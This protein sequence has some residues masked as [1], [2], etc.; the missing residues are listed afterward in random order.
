MSTPQPILLILCSNSERRQFLLKEAGFRFAVVPSQFHEGGVSF[1]NPIVTGKAIARGKIETVAA[2]LPAE[3][4]ALGESVKSPVAPDVTLI[5]CDTMVELNGMI[6]GK[7]SDHGDARRILRELSGQTHRVYS[8]VAIQRLGPPPAPAAPVAGAPAA[9]PR[10]H[11][12]IH[13]FTVM[14]EVTFRELTP[15]DIATYIETGES[16]DKAGAYGIQGHGRA[17]VRNWKG[18]VYNVI[19]FPLEEFLAHEACPLAAR[20]DPSKMPSVR[21]QDNVIAGK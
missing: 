4:A 6:Y 8:S 13:L 10:A 17:L 5:G 12:K 7:P 20:V 1:S 9:P 18:S 16:M 11:N 21:F 3:L 19:G 14:T 15:A 2:K